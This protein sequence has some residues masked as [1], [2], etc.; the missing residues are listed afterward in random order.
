[1]SC[2]DAVRLFE[3]IPRVRRTLQT[4]CDV[5]LD[6]L[7]LGQSA[8][9]LSGGE[10]QRVKLAAELSRP[11]TGRTLY[12]LDEPT[13]GL[14]FDDLAKLLE[15]LNRLVDMGNTIVVIEHNLDVVKTADWIIDI[16]PEAGDGGGR[17]VVAGTPEDVAAHGQAAL[18]AHLQSQW[19]N[20]QSPVA[21]STAQPKRKRSTTRKAKAT[22]EPVA[23]TTPPLLR[24]YT[25]EA[26]AAVLAAGPHK[27]RSLYDFAAEVAKREGD[28]EIRQVGQET[29]MPWEVDGR[30]WHT[31]ERVSRSGQPSRWDGRILD[32]VERFVQKEGVFS[33]TNWNAR[34]IVEI[35]ADRKSD[36]W[37]MHAI[38]GETWLL[39]L[40]FR[41]A[42]NTFGRDDLASKLKLTPLNELPDLPVYGH[43]P[44][45]RCKNLRGPWQ[46][47]Q[48][49][50]HSLAEVDRPEFWDFVKKAVEGF[51]KYI[52]RLSQSPE[53]VM[54][55]TVLGRKWHATRKGFPPGK[56]VRWDPDLLEQLCDM[57][58]GAAPDGQFLWNNQHVVHFMIKQQKEPWASLYT[59]KPE[60]IDLVL[61]GPKDQFAL[62][63]IAGFG[64]ARQVT[65]RESRDQ[66]K[67][68]FREH[69]DLR[70]SELKRFLAEHLASIAIGNGG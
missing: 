50:L 5:G 49:D 36:G 54:P 51:K 55:W 67:I 35:S 66:L 62:G 52:E 68:R 65:P 21:Q 7:T 18:R 38:T 16:G 11:D 33:P 48:I 57:L 9:T 8:P 39:K 17:I 64:A 12:L 44:R 56:P 41:V 19:N 70:P 15:V 32:R 30:R 58:A 43:G 60:G 59:K 45:V 14:H 20:D 34:T 61:T 25:G 42:K 46:E 6:Y 27:K 10:A 4:L 29:D 13:T 22:G 2:G 53:A 24:S 69:G 28:L 3:N 1:M 23:A 31:R 47:V 37:F 63:R 40:K 26:L